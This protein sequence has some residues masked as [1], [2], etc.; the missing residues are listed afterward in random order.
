MAGQKFVLRSVLARFLRRTMVV[1]RSSIPTAAIIKVASSTVITFLRRHFVHDTERQEQELLHD[2]GVVELFELLDVAAA[3][4]R[5]A[6]LLGDHV[7]DA[8]AELVQRLLRG[9]D[10][11]VG[12]STP[13]SRPC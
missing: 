3:E 12:P 9:T 7:H 5:R 1:R 11:V 2:L 4:L 6:E 8:L 13:R 10:V